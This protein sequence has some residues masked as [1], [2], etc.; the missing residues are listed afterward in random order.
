VRAAGALLAWDRGVLVVR[1]GRGGGGGG[2]RWGPGSP[3]EVGAFAPLAQGRGGGGGDGAW[4]GRESARRQAA[5]KRGDAPRGGAGA[6][7]GDG[8]GR[9]GDRTGGGNDVRRAPRKRKRGFSTLR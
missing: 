1:R 6:R 7:H 3:R 2:K 9:G 5:N 8:R 4:G